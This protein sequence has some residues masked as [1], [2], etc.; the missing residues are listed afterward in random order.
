MIGKQ[1][2]I[3]AAK[4]KLA[5]SLSRLILYI[6]LALPAGKILPKRFKYAYE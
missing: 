6:Y 5:V 2:G 4:I 1:P 3:I